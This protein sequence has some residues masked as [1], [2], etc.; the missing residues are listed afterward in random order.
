VTVEQDWEAAHCQQNYR[1]LSHRMVRV[2]SVEQIRVSHPAQVA[3]LW[4]SRCNGR[5]HSLH[6][7]VCSLAAGWAAVP[8]AHLLMVSTLVELLEV[9]VEALNDAG[10][11]A[12]D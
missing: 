2:G 5:D 3:A 1:L 9:A 11:E 10:A 12:A 6:P 4:M 8:L 7:A